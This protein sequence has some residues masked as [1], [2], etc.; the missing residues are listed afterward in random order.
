MQNIDWNDWKSRII[1]EGLVDKV[2]EN[3]EETNKE[4]YDLDRIFTDVF[5]RDSKAIDDIVI[6]LISRTTR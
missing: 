2:K 4:Q 1:T 6:S 3:Y 5:S